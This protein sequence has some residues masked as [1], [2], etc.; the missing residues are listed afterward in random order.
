[1]KATLYYYDNLNGTSFNS[2]KELDLEAPSIHFDLDDYDE[3][4]GNGHVTILLY[5]VVDVDEAT[6]DDVIRTIHL[7]GKHFIMLDWAMTEDEIKARSEKREAQKATADI[8]GKPMASSHI[9][10]QGPFIRH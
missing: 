9:E 2:R 10:I 1:M 8:A 4:S 6:S 5:D 7:D 3:E